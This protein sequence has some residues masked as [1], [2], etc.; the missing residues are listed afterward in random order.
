MIA[1]L[2]IIFDYS[3]LCKNGVAPWIVSA[4]TGSWTYNFLRNFNRIFVKSV[5]LVEE[6]SSSFSR[7]NFLSGGRE[8]KKKKR[9]REKITIPILNR[10]SSE[11]E[12]EEKKFRQIILLEFN[13]NECNQFNFTLNG[14]KERE[15]RGAPPQAS[16]QRSPCVS[17]C[18][19]RPCASVAEADVVTPRFTVALVGNKSCPVNM[20]PTADLPRVARLHI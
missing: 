6:A 18:G 17:V 5:T 11:R 8:G 12:R 2:S 3:S 7:G 9:R 13:W 10:K 15:K 4:S 19:C 16:F 1:L 14:E 20:S